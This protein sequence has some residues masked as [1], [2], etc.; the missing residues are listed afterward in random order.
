MKKLILT[1]CALAMLVSPLAAQTNT[2]P[3]PTN[4]S[5][6][7]GGALTLG[8]DLLNFLTDA[9]PYYGQG[10][11]AGAYGLYNNKKFGG[12]VDL[13]YPLTAGGNISAGGGLAYLNGQFYSFSLSVNMGTTWKLPL[14]GNVYTWLESGPYLNVHS[15]EPGVQS[16][17]GVTKDIQFG[18]ASKATHVYLTGGV[19]N[20]ST[21]PGSTYIAGVSFKLPGW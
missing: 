6:L 3:T 14:V 18:N 10:L 4:T 2:S 16:F 12:L 15:H 13:Q 5:A 11:R 17:A 20:I 9:V 8:S 1:L 19:G 21:S 7:P